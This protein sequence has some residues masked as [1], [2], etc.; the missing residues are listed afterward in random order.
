MALSL[1]NGVRRK[2]DQLVSIDLGARTTKAV[3]LERQGAG[4]ALS[5]YTLLDAPIYEKGLTADLLTEHLKAVLHALD[6]KTRSVTVAL[7]TAGAF[8][9][10]AELPLM[11]LS[12]VREVLKVSSKTYLQQDFPGH[13]FDCQFA[14]LN[15]AGRP[16]EKSKGAMAIPRQ[17]ALVAGA[18][19][20]L[21]DSVH[22]AV[23]QAGMFAEGVVPALI[24]PVNAFE[25][26]MPDVFTK[27]PVALVDI[28]FKSTSICLLYEGDLAL[29][30]VVAIGGD[31]LTSGLAEAMGIS[32]AEA[33][34][35]K[36]GIPSEVQ[37]QLES[38]LL[39]LGRELRAS[40]DC[41]E[42][43]HDKA[44]TQ[45]FISGGSANSEFIVNAL[46]AELMAECK[47][48]NPLSSITLALAPQQTAQLEQVA[49]QLTVAVGAAMSTF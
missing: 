20:Q 22:T 46:Q 4:M 6:T 44:I 47:L 37:A 45:V 42:H 19:R 35:I 14:K 31:K 49:T 11:P 1:I 15:G 17:R 24:G 27:G 9:R 23:R 41:F 2:C 8:V 48:W 21:V 33:E 7:D 43:Q 30:R 38:L 13:V 5:S 36:V 18:S 26:A 39:P 25:H 28:G 32:Y 16:A 34:S 10:H 40:I 3:H 12:D 29:S